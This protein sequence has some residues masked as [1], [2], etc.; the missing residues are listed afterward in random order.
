MMENDGGGGH[1]PSPSSHHD[2]TST[3]RGAP[4]TTN[5]NSEGEK[6]SAAVPSWLDADLPEWVDEFTRDAPGHSTRAASPPDDGNNKKSFANQN[7]EQKPASTACN[8]PSN[9]EQEQEQQQR[10]PLSSFETLLATNTHASNA[11]LVNLTVPDIA[12]FALVCRAARRM[13][14]DDGL[15]RAKFAMRWNVLP[16][17]VWT[18]RESSITIEEGSNDPTESKATQ[19][20][21][22]SIIA[23]DGLTDSN[24]LWFRS[25][26]NAH[27]NLHDL[28]ITHWNC[29]LPSDGTSPGRC[30]VPDLRLVPDASLPQ[31]EERSASVSSEK[32]DD[33]YDSHLMERCPTCRHHP[34]INAKLAEM[35]DALDAEMKFAE[36]VG[37][38][39]DDPVTKSHA[40]AEAHAL[41]LRR[42]L[43][44]GEEA[45]HGNELSRFKVATT[46]AKAIYYSSL[47]SAS[48]WARNLREKDNLDIS[49]RSN[50]HWDARP[51]DSFT[52]GNGD[53][54]VNPAVGAS[55]PCPQLDRMVHRRALSVSA[56]Q[57]AATCH[58]QIDPAQY[59][60]SGLQFM[61]DALFFN[62]DPTYEKVRDETGWVG[63]ISCPVGRKRAVNKMNLD[64][65]AIS[66]ENR[67][68][69]E[70]TDDEH[71][72]PVLERALR[73]VYGDATIDAN[74]A[75]LPSD[76][77][78]PQLEPNAPGTLS[79]RGPQHDTA[80]HT[81]HT[82]RLSN[83]DFVRPITFRVY[84]QRPDCF[85]AFPARGY[86]RPGESCEIVLGVRTLG[87]VV[88]E[89][90]ESIDSGRE[91]VDPLLADVYAKEAHLPYA[92]F[93]IRYM[94]APAPPCI[95]PGYKVREE[96][97][98]S[99]AGVQSPMT[100]TQTSA[101]PPSSSSA[102]GGKGM[103]DYLWDNIACETDVRTIYVSAHVNANYS[104]DEFLGRTLLPFEIKPRQMSQESKE[105]TAL[106]F[107]SPNLKQSSPNL[108]QRLNNIDLEMEESALGGIYRTEKACLCCGRAWGARSEEFA[109]G[110][111]LSRMVIDRRA[112]LRSR[113][114]TNA[115][116]YVRLLPKLLQRSLLNGA[117]SE[118]EMYLDDDLFCQIHRI[119]FGLSAIL[120]LLRADKTPTKMQRTIATKYEIFLNDLLLFI[121]DDGGFDDL[122]EH[123]SWRNVGI[124]R[125]LRCTDSIYNLSNEVYRH[126]KSEPKYLETFCNLWHSPGLYRLGAQDD[127]NHM[128]EQE[129]MGSGPYGSSR[130]A[131]RL[132]RIN[133]RHA[134]V[135]KQDA[136]MALACAMSMIHSPRSLLLHGVYDRLD[137]PGTI[138]RRAAPWEFQQT[139]S[140]LKDGAPSSRQV[141]LLAHQCIQNFERGVSKRS[142]FVFFGRAVQH[143]MTSSNRNTILKQSSREILKSIAILG[144]KSVSIDINDA[145]PEGIASLVDG[146]VTFASSL[147]NFV[148]NVPG[149]GHGRFLLSD[150]RILPR[151]HRIFSSLDNVA[152]FPLSVYTPFEMNAV[153]TSV[154][155]NQSQQ[156]LA[157]RVQ[158]AE[159]AAGNPEHQEERGAGGPRI[160]NLLWLIS[161]HLGWSVDD[162]HRPGAHHVE[163]GILI[164]TQWLSNTLMALP[165]FL[166]LVARY[167]MFIT[168]S[169]LDYHL[170]GLPFVEVKRMRYL[171]AD[172]CGWAALVTVLLYLVLG[173]FSERNVCRSFNRAM[174]EVVQDPRQDDQKSPFQKF[175]SLALLR[176]LRVYDSVTPLFIQSKTFSPRW[177][178]RSRHDVESFIIRSR[179]CDYREHQSSFDA[180]SGIGCGTIDIKR[181]HLEGTLQPN[182][183]FVAK[184]IIGFLVSVGSFCACSPHFSLN[185]ITT[186]YSS[187]ALGLSM[188]LQYMEQG[189][190]S[191]SPRRIFKP[192][193]LN[194]VIITSFLFGQLVGSSGGI[195]FLAEFVVTTISL[196]LGGAATISTNA[197]ESWMTFFF[198]SATSFVGYLFARVALVDNTRN[199]RGGVPSFLLLLSLIL[200]SCLTVCTF[201]FLEWEIPS[202]ALII[203]P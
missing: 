44:H 8:I 157:G 95:P 34:L 57:A 103:I 195:L 68:H 191:L 27:R 136:S 17:P 24:S 129:I 85:T 81:W 61:T 55:A 62:V 156:Q 59:R 105:P 116:N 196:L 192:M 146:I 143:P 137:P 141:R 140:R 75:S 169:P 79:S 30:A 164:A 159:G 91:E 52:G 147:E 42:D 125:F 142:G 149:A 73:D 138:C 83:P 190:G 163:R 132:Q 203:R 90:Y 113:Q 66:D 19:R 69:Q 72:M 10:S 15:W 7:Q 56:F 54:P 37:G 45:C 155:S 189:N 118:E 26:Q 126:G 21:P 87:S 31:S 130:P 97:A 63:S 71:D 178:R 22:A 106:T 182:I 127:P 201:L 2:V 162:D 151:M 77:P 101:L 76:P 53:G 70:G 51:M 100:R 3:H 184:V 119:G 124:Y 197:V 104:F 35:N 161:S 153:V 148:H 48:K 67:L 165:L 18:V 139:F 20:R 117:T 58:R 176:G 133:W 99:F 28:W 120:L 65:D 88:A 40:I 102:I 108:F 23:G 82:A 172:E 93:A 167:L 39:H 80:L 183:S 111:L 49:M 174:L 115:L 194:V 199:K 13:T 84:V 198:L 150:A 38:D 60:S 186:F 6:P 166:T 175:C 152:I 160:I 94:F 11:L 144:W 50:P 5:N 131:K 43:G 74:A 188:S 41:L 78:P 92:P 114:I 200:L 202:T 29:T 4:H 98:S 145:D 36:R 181:L 110:F 173:R 16:A 32:D 154:P 121:Q 134:D 135:F 109:R 12:N 180:A 158:A 89:A 128:R 187:I 9:D 185:V 33:G 86:L 46:P 193:R 96:K 1:P 171:D 25:Y 170:E 47:C 179:G 168:P 14:R 177:N 64:P 123:L 107:L 112:R 122:P